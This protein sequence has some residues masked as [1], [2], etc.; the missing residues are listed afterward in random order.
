MNRKVERGGWSKDRGELNP[1]QELG[2]LLA[3]LEPADEI[4]P[5]AKVVRLVADAAPVHAPWYLGLLL[6]GGRRLR[7]ALAAVLVLCMGSGMLAVMPAQ[8]A[9]VGTLILARLP[10]AWTVGSGALDEFQRTSEAYFDALAV[11]QSELFIKVAAGDGKRQLALSLVGIDKG[12]AREFFGRLAEKF[13][14]LDAQPPEYLPIDSNRFGSRLNELLSMLIR[15]G[16]IEDMNEGDIHVLVL[17]SLAQV[18]LVPDSIE[19]T[20]L[21][22][23]GIIIEIDA[24]MRIPVEG[25]T[26]DDL[27]AAGLS[28]ELLGDEAYRQVLEDLA[29][30]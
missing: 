5:W 26:Q 24:T 16:S 2:R 11:P 15:P 19:I 3:S 20:H 21:D 10:S 30:R 8:S 18:G 29:V 4:L 12:S 27:A 23:G 22:D 13:P 6:Y 28:K 9:Q 17:E 14:A 25:S 7:Y 1:D